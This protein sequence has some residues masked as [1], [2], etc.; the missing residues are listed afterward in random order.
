[1]RSDL[2]FIVN[3]I[4]LSGSGGM[5]EIDTQ[6]LITGGMEKQH[7][8]LHRQYCNFIVNYSEYLRMRLKVG[9]CVRIDIK[10]II[11]NITVK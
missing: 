1:M 9:D 4:K 10:K 11:S 6:I 3:T 2:E 7:D 8:G 5:V